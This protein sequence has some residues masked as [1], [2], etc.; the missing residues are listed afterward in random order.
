MQEAQLAELIEPILAQF[1]LELDALDV[2]PVGKRAV[3]RITVDGDGPDGTG[4][5]LDDIAEAT[6]AV[7]A[8]LDESPAT[9]DAPYTLEVSS[10]GVSK[11]LTEP[12][13]FRRNHGRLVKLTLEEG[14]VTGRIVGVDDE[15]PVLDV[16]GTHRTFPMESIRKAVVQI[17]MNRKEA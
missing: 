6:Q 16:T 17:E 13:H 12:K 4:P 2:T 7:S 8:A 3:L 9:G 11:P 15:G 5:L 10:R 14:E 1:G